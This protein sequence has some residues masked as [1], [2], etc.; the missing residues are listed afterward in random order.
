MLKKWTYIEAD[1]QREYG[2]NLQLE[3]FSISFRRFRALVRGFSKDSV[4]VL[5]LSSLTR[6]EAI[7]QKPASISEYTP[8]TEKAIDAVWG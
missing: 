2:I 8:E 5:Y 6:P 3:F 7:K 1:F 4:F